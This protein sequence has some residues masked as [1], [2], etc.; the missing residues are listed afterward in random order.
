MNFH[1]L[2][3]V[4]HQA[5]EKMLKGEVFRGNVEGKDSAEVKNA[6]RPVVAE[7][8][9]CVVEIKCDGQK[10]GAGYRRR[11]RWLGAVQGQPTQG[12]DGLPHARRPGTGSP[13]RRCQLGV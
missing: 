6:F 10:A 1:V 9:R 7:A 4:Y 2:I 13:D 11:A 3:D 8:G 5:W 12:K